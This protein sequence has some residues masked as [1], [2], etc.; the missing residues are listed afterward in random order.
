MLLASER[1]FAFHSGLIAFK[2][3][4]IVAGDQ[5]FRHFQLAIRGPLQTIRGFRKPVQ[6]GAPGRILFS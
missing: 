4:Q 3:R 5:K 1:D 6:E 2:K